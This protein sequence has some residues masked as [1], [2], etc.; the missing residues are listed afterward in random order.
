MAVEAVKSGENMCVAA[1]EVMLNT[2]RDRE[3][4]LA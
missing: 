2:L 3:L 4:S 1:R